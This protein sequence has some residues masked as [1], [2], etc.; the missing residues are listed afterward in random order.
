MELDIKGA[1]E[2]QRVILPEAIGSL[3][4]FAIESEYRPA[5]EV[6]GDFFQV[7]PHISD[8]SLLIVAGDVT[9]KGLQ[10]GML[11][12]LLVGAEC[13]AATGVF[14]AAGAGSGPRRVAAA[15]ADGEFDPGNGGRR[16]GVGLCRDGDAAAGSMGADRV[17][18]CAG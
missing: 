7:I 17:Q 5:R 9:G 3:P 10:A 16:A 13:G 15:T 14:C 2:V 8:G 18:P 1:Q 12:A 4:G 11:V 6:G